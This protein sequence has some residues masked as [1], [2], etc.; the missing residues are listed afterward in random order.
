MPYARML[1]K[2]DTHRL[3]KYQ[4]A[5]LRCQSTSS[6]TSKPGHTYLVCTSYRWYHELSRYMQHGKKPASKIPISIRQTTMTL[7]SFAH[8]IPSITS[9]HDNANPFSCSFGPIHR[10]DSVDGNSKRKYVMKKTIRAIE[11]RSPMSKERSLSIPA[12]RAFERLTRSRP[13][14][15]YNKPRIGISLQSTFRL[16]PCQQNDIDGKQV[17]IHYACFQLSP[18]SRDTHIFYPR[19]RLLLLKNVML[20]A[21]IH[22]DQLIRPTCLELRKKIVELWDLVVDI[23][24][25]AETPSPQ[26]LHFH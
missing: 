13:A 2:A 12:T 18:L 1:P 20:R 19:D 8:P 21:I 16:G 24:I 17:G 11:Y 25:G 14:I 23:A 6:C 4:K 5:I 9:P 22:V 7:Q 15:E 26:G 10:S 3:I